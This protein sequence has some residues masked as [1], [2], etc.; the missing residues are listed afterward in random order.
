[1]FAK[2]DLQRSLGQRPWTLFMRDVFPGVLPLAMLSMAV[3]QLDCS[4]R[5]LDYGLTYF[6]AKGDFQRSLG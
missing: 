4:L 3:G 5:L 2:G 6:F 1:L